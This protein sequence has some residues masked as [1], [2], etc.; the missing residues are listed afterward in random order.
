MIMTNISQWMRYIGSSQPDGYQ[1]NQV[2]F[3]NCITSVYGV[4][5]RTQ[6]GLFMRLSK[7]QVPDYFIASAKERGPKIDGL[8]S[9]S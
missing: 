2:Y 8:L 3:V 7:S 4:A 6:S 5:L 9:N 1:H